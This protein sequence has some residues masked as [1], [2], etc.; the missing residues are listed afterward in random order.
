VEWD[1]EFSQGYKIIVF[2]D[3]DIIHTSLNTLPDDLK[4]N[5][6]EMSVARIQANQ[7]NNTIEKIKITINDIAYMPAQVSGLAVTV[8]LLRKKGAAA[9]LTKFGDLEFVAKIVE[10]NGGQLFCLLGLRDL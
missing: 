7:L 5:W 8:T 9:R 2:T 3:T 6:K 4:I 1:A 10:D